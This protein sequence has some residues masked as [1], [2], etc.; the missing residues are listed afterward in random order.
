MKIFKS[1]FEPFLDVLAQTDQY[2]T[3]T[4]SMMLYLMG[5]RIIEKSF[6]KLLEHPIWNFYATKVEGHYF[7]KFKIDFKPLKQRIDA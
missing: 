1:I 7:K 4:K 5:K 2:M 6:R 3:P